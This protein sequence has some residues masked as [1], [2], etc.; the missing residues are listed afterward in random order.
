M[1]GPATKATA[2][3]LA[4]A[5]R[6]AAR[7][8]RHEEIAVRAERGEFADYYGPHPCPITECYRVC[9]EYG[10]HSIAGRL[11]NG[12]FDATK[13]ESDEWAESEEGKDAVLE[14]SPEL[15]RAMF[16]V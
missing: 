11:L 3:R 2:D 10:L 6:I 15:R 13:A 14:L 16:G 5:I 8:K 7:E 12:E 4:K 9:V 1:M